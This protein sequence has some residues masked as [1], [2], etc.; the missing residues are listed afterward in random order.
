MK[1]VAYDQARA[2]LEKAHRLDEVKDIA[3]KAEAMRLYAK[4]ARDPDMEIWL[5]E[6]RLR[7]MR[8]LGEL[9][10]QLEKAPSGPGRGRKRLPDTGTPFKRETLKRVGISSAQAHRC[11]MIAK[12]PTK[13]FE[14]YIAQRARE[15]KPVTVDDVVSKVTRERRRDARLAKIVPGAPDLAT[16][17]EFS[18]IYA[19]PPWRYDYSLSDSRKI[20]GQYPT[21]TSEEIASLDVPAAN[22]AILFLWVPSPKLVEGLAVLAAWNFEYRTCMVWEKAQIGMGYY[23]RQKHELL[24]IATLGDLP[25]PKP[26]NRP[27]SVIHAKRTRHSEKPVEFYEAIERMYPELKDSRVELFQRKPRQGWQGWG[28]EV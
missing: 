15:R 5:A 1:L 12:I 13:D 25:P 9:S 8:R 24:L 20:E 14:V 7:A 16:V 26:A 27:A 18:L 10:K 4:Q 17:G 3:D 23:A 19:D 6:I 2:A 22:D 11:E 21:M 28:F